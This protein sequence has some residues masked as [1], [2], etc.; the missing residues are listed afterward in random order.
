MARPPKWSLQVNVDGDL[1]I[2][3]S[4]RNAGTSDSRIVDEINRA[5]AAGERLLEGCFDDS[6]VKNVALNR[7]IGATGRNLGEIDTYNPMPPLVKFA[8][9]GKPVARGRSRDDACSECGHLGYSSRKR[10]VRRRRMT[11]GSKI[12]ESE[13]M[14][15]TIRPATSAGCRK[16]L[17]S[18]S[19]KRRPISVSMVPME[20]NQNRA[21]VCA[22]SSFMARTKPSRPCLT[23]Q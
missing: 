20:N 1:P 18:C 13:Q 5:T 9:D 8:G 21:F 6:F 4:L 11:S 19:V 2:R 10:M 22:Y 3:V 14:A 23:A 12:F 7:V 16:L 17:R 15:S